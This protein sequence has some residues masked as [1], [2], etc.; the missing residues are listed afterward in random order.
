M[1]LS[2]IPDGIV[3]P[4]SSLARAMRHG[5]GS[6]RGRPGPA[7]APVH[8]GAGRAAWCAAAPFAVV[9]VLA[10]LQAQWTYTGYDASALEP[11]TVGPLVNLTALGWVV[12]ISAVFSL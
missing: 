7:M 8:A 5:G 6:S 10:L 9:F 3:P 1:P 4:C 2:R 11:G 12:V